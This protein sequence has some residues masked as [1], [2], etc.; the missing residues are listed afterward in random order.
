MKG[1]HPRC[2]TREIQLSFG[3]SHPTYKRGNIG[4]GGISGHLVEK[5]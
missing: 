2:L 3:R 1:V 5:D 4:H